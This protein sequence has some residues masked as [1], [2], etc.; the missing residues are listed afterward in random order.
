M[1]NRMRNT[2]R[3]PR[4]TNCSICQKLIGENSPTIAVEYGFGHSMPPIHKLT[5]HR[6]CYE[7]TG[8][9]IVN[10]LLDTYEL[11]V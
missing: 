2:G 9:N 4:L 7:E 8:E 5:V 1:K 6:D 3:P 11:V 10:L